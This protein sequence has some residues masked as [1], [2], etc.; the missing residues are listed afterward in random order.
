MAVGG[1]THEMRSGRN[2]MT[3]LSDRSHLARSSLPN[4][5]EWHEGTST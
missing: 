5:S 3:G 1:R 2:G 4:P